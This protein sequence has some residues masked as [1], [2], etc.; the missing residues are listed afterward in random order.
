[1]M[2]NTGTKSGSS[3]TSTG[4]LSVSG[5]QPG[6]MTLDEARQ[7]AFTG[8]VVFEGDPDVLVYLDNGVVYYAERTSDASLGR[9]LLDAGVVDR[10]QLERGTVRVGDVEHLGRLF[11][12]EAS[13][14]RDAVLVVT[15][16]ST[17]D[18]I[19]ELANHTVT[20]VRVT[21][22]RHHP[23]GVHRWFVEQLD[24]AAVRPMGSVV[25]PVIAAEFRGVDL[26]LDVSDDELIIQWDDLSDP[27]SPLDASN[28]FDVFMF[29]P[30]RDGDIAVVGAGVE[31][32]VDEITIE[33]G[34]SE[35]LDVEFE[36]EFEVDT[37]LDVDTEFDSEVE[38]VPESGVVGEFEVDTELETAPDDSLVEIVA[39]DDD[40]TDF[41]VTWPN[42]TEEPVL[43][44][45]IDVVPQAAPAFTHSDNGDLR[46][47]MPALELSDDDAQADEVPDDVAAA[48]RRAIAAIE[49][50]SGEVPVIA[51]IDFDPFDDTHQLP[52]IE[53]S[54]SSLGGFAPPTMAMRAEVMYAEAEEAAAATARLGQ[55]SLPPELDAST[56]FVDDRSSQDAASERSSALRR[57]IGSLRRKD[58]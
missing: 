1:M 32:S 48:V 56:V 30:V 28:A 21:A 47:E 5:P 15:E 18:L 43:V 36:I 20:T 50:V 27:T 17:E 19:T 3:E 44:E 24:T 58:H 55:S 22:Y 57:L 38:S 51:P 29:D 52:I 34:A 13:I 49:M 25:D 2:H 42:A 7:R 35:T 14:D 46:F 4:A 8:E 41:Q 54:V 6:W 39:F 33:F 26:G 10:I 37:D 16:T 23:S 11:D 45:A 53:P 40:P 31:S 9:R 12:R